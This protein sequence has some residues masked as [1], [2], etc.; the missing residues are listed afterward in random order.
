MDFTK[1]ALGIELGSTRIKA[2]LID[3][4]HIPIASGDFEWENQLVDGIWTY[5]MDMVRTGV[6]SCF[7]AL[8]ADVR[9]KFGAELDTVG[10]IGVSAM[11]HGYLPF[12]K[13][14]KQL[15]EFRTWRNTITGE[16]AEKLTA[17]FGFNIPQ[18]WSIAH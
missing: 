3:E 9:A 18:R 8:K 7:A 13:D 4:K 2:V 10:A 17:L 6:Q 5:S 1:T 14:G 11:M 16:A 15:A 12:D